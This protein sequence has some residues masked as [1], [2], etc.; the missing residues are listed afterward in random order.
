MALQAMT[1]LG[2]DGFISL[3]SD[4]INK[5]PRDLTLVGPDQKQF[6]SS[7]QELSE[8]IENVQVSQSSVELFG[9]VT[10]Q[11]SATPTYNIP[12][13]P[14]TSTLTSLDN[15][16]SVLGTVTDLFGISMRR[17]CY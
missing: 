15:N 9:R 13:Y 1:Q 2:E 8:E 7:S 10:P 17:R 5:I 6:R 4:N 3:F 11:N 12:F 14:N 16:V